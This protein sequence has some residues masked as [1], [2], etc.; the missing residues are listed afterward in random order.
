MGRWRYYAQRA[1][2]GEWLHRDLPLRDVRITERISAPGQIQA[3]IDPMH[4]NLVGPDG[5]PLLDEW[6]TLIYAECDGQIR[7]GGILVDSSFTGQ[8]WELDIAGFT[9]YAE[10]QPIISTLTWGGPS[11]GTTGNGADP[12]TVVRGLWAHLQTQPDGDL[13]VVVDSAS[14][15]YRLGSWHN[16]RRVEDDGDLGPANEV[17]D[18]IPI[19][20]V[21]GVDDRKPA[22]ATGKTV[23]WKYEI[24]WWENKQVG[25]LTTELGGQ[26]PFDYAETYTWTS[27]AREAVEMR[28]R[29]G[30]PRLGRALTSRFVQGENILQVI[31][32]QRSGDD[33]ANSIHAYGSGEG[34]KQLRS[35]TTQ[36][37]GRLRRAD[38]VDRPDLTTTAA[39]KS[40]A[41]DELGRRVH[42]VDIAGFTLQ[43][44]PHAPLST[45]HP[46]DDILVQTRGGWL[47][48]RL[49]VRVTAKTTEP[50]KATAQIACQR[51][52]R[53]NYS[54][55]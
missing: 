51:R 39:L 55:S 7:A 30:Y 34:S 1:L 49:W 53:F 41:A 36:R 31:P 15:P 24:P 40:V 10:G 46:G 50:D 8:S 14:C 38:V 17:G 54:G 22:A 2:T 44:H 11:T 19:D 48:T 9:A 21:P 27:S 37:D 18:P 25:Q 23:Y 52:D 47:P 3:T 16:A 43:D 26:V 29:L 28:L 5:A 13:G 12:F 33:Y 4:V 42:L 32:V 6:S 20:R 45:V 35:S